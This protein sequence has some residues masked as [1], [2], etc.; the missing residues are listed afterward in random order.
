MKKIFGALT[1]V[2]IV[3]LV[4][5]AGAS[6]VGRIPI[7]Q[8]CMQVIAAVGFLFSGMVGVQVCRIDEI[9]TKRSKKLRELRQKISA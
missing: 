1:I 4:G 3:L 8:A 2:G 9:K 6:D 7:S 5:T